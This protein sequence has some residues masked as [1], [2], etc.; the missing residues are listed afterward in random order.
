MVLLDF[1]GSD[2]CAVCQR[3]NQDVFDT[4]EFKDYARDNLELV[5]VD[6]PHDKP[7]RLATVKQ[8]AELM[9]RYHVETLPVFVL[10]DAKGTLV[11]V[12][13]GYQP[14]GPKAFVETL[15]KLRG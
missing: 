15:K 11:K 4:R 1:T 12:L 13:E 8:N 14:G 9:N 6:F 10:L 5:E 3:M 2:W 7:L